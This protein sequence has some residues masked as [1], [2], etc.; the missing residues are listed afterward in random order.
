MFSGSQAE[1]DNQLHRIHLRQPLRQNSVQLPPA[2]DL[3]EAGAD[4]SLHRQRALRAEAEGAQ[5]QDRAESPGI[6]RVHRALTPAPG[7]LEPL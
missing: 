3:R 1:G 6:S 7:L 4:R 2:P 5:T